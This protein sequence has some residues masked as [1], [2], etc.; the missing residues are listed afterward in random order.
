[1]E[2]DS[3]SSLVETDISLISGLGSC[4]GLEPIVSYEY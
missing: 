1:M 4:V 2:H 3:V